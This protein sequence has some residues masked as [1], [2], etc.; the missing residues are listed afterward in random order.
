MIKKLAS[1]IYKLIFLFLKF[2]DTITKKRLSYAFKDEIQKNSYESIDIKGKKTNFF[3]PNSFTKY[4]LSTFYFKE[5]DT[6]KWLNEFE[7]KDNLIFWDIGANVGNYSIYAAQKY[8]SINVVAFEPSHS[9]LRILSRNISI[10]NLSNKI[11]IIQLPLSNQELQLNLMNETDFVEGG[12]FNSFKETYT[13]SKQKTNWK[14]SYKILGTS[15][16]YLVE[17][18]ILNIPDY[19]KIDV[20]GIEHLILEGAKKT[21]QLECCRSI[22]VEINEELKDQSELSNK[23][24]TD[25]GYKIQNKLQSTFTNKNY[26]FEK[27]YN[28]IWV[29]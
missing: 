28:Q 2:F 22:L 6:I 15:I 29:K 18:K 19:I 9:N 10:N 21:L 25:S 3:I 17:K 24:L 27:I 26:E 11:N 1:L 20:D 5:P 4:R 12:S 23:I 7:D 8:N 16:D 14:N 13:S